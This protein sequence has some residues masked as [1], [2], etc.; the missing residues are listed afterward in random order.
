MRLVTLVAGV[1]VDV[2][3]CNFDMSEDVIVWLFSKTSISSPTTSTAQTSPPFLPIPKPSPSTHP[4]PP[5]LPPLTLTFPTGLSLRYATS[6]TSYSMNAPLLIAHF[7]TPSPGS[8][9]FSASLPTCSACVEFKPHLPPGLDD[10]VSFAAEL[11][12]LTVTKDVSLPTSPLLITSSSLKTKWR[13]QVQSDISGLSIS[14]TEGVAMK[15]VKI[16]GSGAVQYWGDVQWGMMW[17]VKSQMITRR[18]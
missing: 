3:E 16:S 15:T 18:L 10:S 2:R 9:V 5:T 6:I 17:L 8:L 11:A 13:G 1:G 12:A 4:P 7:M 14:Y